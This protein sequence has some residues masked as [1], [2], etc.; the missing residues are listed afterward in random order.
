MIRSILQ[1]LLF[2]LKFYI[3]YDLIYYEML[4]YNKHYLIYYAILYYTK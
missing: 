2:S 3:Y 1:Q 4:Y